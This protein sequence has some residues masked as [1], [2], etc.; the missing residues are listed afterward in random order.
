MNYLITE[1][2]RSEGYELLDSGE[3]EKLERY[4]GIVMSRPDPQ[5]LWEK[6]LPKTDWNK[7]Q[8]RFILP[9]F[10]GQNL[11]ARAR[12]S[13]NAK[14]ELAP[15]VPPKWKIDFA[16]LA[17]LIRPTAFKHTGLFPEHA[18]NWHWIEEK[19]LT[20]GRP[21]SVINLFGYTGGATLAAAKAGASVVHV[22]GSRV[23][24]SWARENAE[25]SKLGNAPIRWIT[26]D[27]RAFLKRELKRGKRYDGIILDPPA[28]GHGTDGKIWKIEDDLLPFLGLCKEAMNDA[29]LFFL[30]N[31]YASGY[32]AI[33]Y[34][35]D[36]ATLMG[37]D[38]GTIEMG[39]LTIRESGKEG[40]LLPCGIFSRWS[41]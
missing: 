5:A 8:A 24:V 11:G 41:K 31:G 2:N 10:V 20:A 35:N 15:S 27:A 33:A 28:F 30:M 3:G 23:A 25:A 13:A 12:A 22:D 19:I 36:L 39:E 16:G 17:F 1:T 18:P 26:D 29:P 14:W 40:R 7:A 4:G 37:K 32:S 34:R 6:R 38:K 21:V 9:S